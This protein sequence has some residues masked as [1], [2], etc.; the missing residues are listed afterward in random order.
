MT[1]EVTHQRRPDPDNRLEAG[2]GMNAVDTLLELSREQLN[3]QTGALRHITAK[4]SIVIGIAGI[5]ATGN[6][7]AG[8]NGTVL[9]YLMYA[10]IVGCFCFG[11]SAIRLR[12][13]SDGPDLRRATEILRNHTYNDAKEWVANAN[14]ISCEHNAKRLIRITRHLQTALVLLVVSVVL[15]VA[16]QV[17]HSA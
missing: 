1:Q 14:I 11:I 8:A 2:M 17:I 9:I 3:D 7:P 4:A 10:A 12:T 15:H 6:M 16:L 13:Y 5:V